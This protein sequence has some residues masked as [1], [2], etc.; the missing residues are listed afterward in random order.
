MEKLFN[1][2]KEQYLKIQG[3]MEALSL[4]DKEGEDEEDLE[5]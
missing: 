5:D 2:K 4:V 3:A 1:S